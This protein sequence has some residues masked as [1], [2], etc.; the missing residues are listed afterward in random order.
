MFRIPSIDATY[1]FVRSVDGDYAVQVEHDNGH[2]V[3]LTDDLAYPGGIGWANEWTTVSEQEV[4]EE[5]RRE[6]L[7]AVDG[8]VDYVLMYD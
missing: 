5:L 2:F 1:R 7:Y 4:P 8:Y 3:I 6:L